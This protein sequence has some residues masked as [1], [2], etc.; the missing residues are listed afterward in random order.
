[1][2]CGIAKAENVDEALRQVTAT[3]KNGFPN[4]LSLMKKPEQ[5][6]ECARNTPA[7][8]E[9][10]PKGVDGLKV[11]DHESAIVAA[12]DVTIQCVRSHNN[13]QDASGLKDGVP[14]QTLQSFSNLLKKVAAQ[15]TECQNVSFNNCDTSTAE[16]KAIA[17]AITELF[18]LKGHADKVKKE[19]SEE[20]FLQV[21][22]PLLSAAS[23]ISNQ[24]KH[25]I[26]TLLAELTNDYEEGAKG[27]LRE[28]GLPMMR[29]IVENPE[30]YKC[31]KEMALE[32]CTILEA[33]IDCDQIKDTNEILEGIEKCRT[34]GKTSSTGSSW[35]IIQKVSS[36]VSNK[37]KTVRNTEPGLSAI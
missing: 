31:P 36:M 2:G 37:D 18:K 24:A 27:I 8:F 9:A 1:M 34:M 21:A 29:K 11:R 12:A 28:G 15:A 19:A 20:Q 26:I 10:I 35:G 5:E 4:L 6:A 17:I 14:N 22:I 33:I 30:E 7:I 3:P 25:E 16:A 13:S 32:C 23:G